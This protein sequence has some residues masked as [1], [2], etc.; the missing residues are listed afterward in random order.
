MTLEHG[1]Q[2]WVD[3]LQAER[4]TQ[5]E[6]GDI[7][8]EARDKHGPT[9]LGQ[10]AAAA[11]RSLRWCQKRLRVATVYGRDARRQYADL[12]WSLFEVAARTDNPELWLSLAAEH[13]WSE[14]EL[15]THIRGEKPQN[16]K[17][18]RLLARVEKMLNSEDGDALE[19]G[20]LELI[21]RRGRDD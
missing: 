4:A 3:M 10:F 8:R 2:R 15:R 12:P 11:G 1:L 20:L 18:A 21:R 14:R 5:W 6:Q 19:E 17:V 7:L 13:G 16:D 9:V